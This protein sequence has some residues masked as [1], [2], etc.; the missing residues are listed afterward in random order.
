MKNSQITED[1]LKQEK[2]GYL[3]SRIHLM[4]GTLSLTHQRLILEAKKT[5]IGGFGLL[6][7]LLGAAATRKTYGFNL[8]FKNI[9]SVSRGKYGIQTVLEITDSQDVLYKIIIKKDSFEEWERL[10]LKLI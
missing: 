3:Y 1:I 4:Q 10:L 5:T 6:G 8:E 7:S 2:V 9:R